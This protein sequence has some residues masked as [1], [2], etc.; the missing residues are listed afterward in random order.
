M[1]AFFYKLLYNAFTFYK[2]YSSMTMRNVIFS[3]FIN[4]NYILF[5]LKPI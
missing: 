5:T 1:G 2:L 4:N 3:F